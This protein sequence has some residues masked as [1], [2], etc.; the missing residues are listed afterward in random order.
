M[1]NISQRNAL[2]SQLEPQDKADLISIM[3]DFDFEAGHEFGEVGDDISHIY[4]VN[5]GIISA[6]A[7]ME[8]GQYAEAYMVG[9]EGFTGVTAWQVPAETSVR[10]FC[11]LAGNAFRVKAAKL[12]GLASQS[13]SLRTTL[14]SYGAALQVELEQAA[15]CNAIHSATQRFA[16]WLLRAHDRANGDTLFMTQE[17]LAK[18]LGVQR[19]TVNDAAQSLAAAGAISYS[20]GRVTIKDRA[21]LE[22]ASC[23]CYLTPE[24]T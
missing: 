18:M 8:D 20:R 2:L 10:F 23:E 21:A 6:V 16:K 12:R 14:A 22:R 4:F 15:P 11:H 7:T 19:T 9:C 17:F 3:S 1:T 24:D 13:E 5:H